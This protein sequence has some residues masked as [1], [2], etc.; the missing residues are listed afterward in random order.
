MDCKETSELFTAYLD[1][2]LTPAEQKLIKEHLAVCL[3]CREELDAL[4]LTQAKLRQTMDVA[5]QHAASSAKAWNRIKQEIEIDSLIPAE[6][7]GQGVKQAT[8]M[9]RLAGL[10]PVTV[11]KKVNISMKGVITNMKNILTSRQPVWRTGLTVMLATALLVSLSVMLP[12]FS[13]QNKEAMAAED[14]VIQILKADPETKALLEDGAVVTFLEKDYLVD[15]LPN[16]EKDVIA[17]I[18]N[19]SGEMNV[20]FCQTNILIKALRM[21]V[22]ITLGD[23]VYMAD[24]DVLNGEVLC[25]GEKGSP[26]FRYIDPRFDIWVEGEVVTEEGESF[27]FFFMTGGSRGF[28]GV[29]SYIDPLYEDQ[30]FRYEPGEFEPGEPLP[31]MTITE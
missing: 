7:G 11:T 6:G 19:A 22:E 8:F 26:D 15:M 16:I 3:L 18:E 4:S 12:S 2:E 9:S 29:Q 21:M 1:G 28:E 24:V 13:G 20:S 27:P 31:N 17:S 5:A 25:F 23:K 30:L 14:E 10:I